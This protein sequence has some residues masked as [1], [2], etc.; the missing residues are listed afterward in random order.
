MIRGVIFD[1]DGTITKPSIDWKSLRARIGV[2]PDQTIIAHIDGL[3]TAAAARANTILESVELEA[4]ASSELNDG[5]RDLLAHL[6]AGGILTAL[7]TN[8][9]ARA[10]QVVLKKHSLSFDVVLCRD[11]GI[12]KPSP[13]LVDKAVSALGVAKP[14]V[15]SIGDGRYDLAASLD[16]GVSFLYITNG[17][18]TLDH[19]P[20][21]AT[22]AEALLWLRARQER[23]SLT[24]PTEGFQG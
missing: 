10:V 24:E 4:C 17:Q 1:M 19:E 22:L 8:N 3:D 20:S 15:L 9:H 2:P 14:E 23:T 6:E 12:L 7:V 5:A 18:P 13:D 21:A 11:D 16:A